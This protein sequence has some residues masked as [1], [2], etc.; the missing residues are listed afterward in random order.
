M[1]VTWI[2]CLLPISYII[3][4][5][6]YDWFW[7]HVNGLWSMN[8]WAKNQSLPCMSAMW[9][10]CVRAASLSPSLAVCLRSWGSQQAE[11]G[12]SWYQRWVMPRL[13]KFASLTGRYSKPRG[14]TRLYVPIFDHVKPCHI[15]YYILLHT[16]HW[17]DEEVLSPLR[18]FSSI[19][20][21]LPTMHF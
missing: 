6:V 4:L 5:W 9:S 7:I 2:T 19:T 11:E 20:L 13:E 16:F 10:S 12:S 1:T 15:L 14:W 18:S 3:V 8:L 21:P 17:L